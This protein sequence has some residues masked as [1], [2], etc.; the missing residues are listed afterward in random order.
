MENKKSK[1]GYLTQSVLSTLIVA[2]VLITSCEKSDDNIDKLSPSIFI[3]GIESEG[4]SLLVD[5][6]EAG[7]FLEIELSDGNRLKRNTVKILDKD[8][9]EV[10]DRTKDLS[11]K[12]QHD[13]VYMDG[14]SINT[15]Y[16]V[17]IETEDVDSNIETFEFYSMVS[18]I[19]KYPHV[20]LIGSATSIGWDIANHLAMDSIS[21]NFFSWE[22][23][24]GAGELKLPLFQNN[25]FC[26]GD[27]IN[28]ATADQDISNPE[29]IYTTGCDGPDN[30]WIITEETAGNYL[31]TVN[32]KDGTM[33]ITKQ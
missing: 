15:F 11:F 7:S 4:D 12:Q 8:G 6:N 22:G 5:Y 26:G 29:F 18:I 19:I 33:T 1:K 24:L 27:W 30:K 28:S 25:D 3:N 17:K 10:Y 21:P 32:T 13:T 14:L 23:P 31:I 16:K 9:N 20:G 2:L